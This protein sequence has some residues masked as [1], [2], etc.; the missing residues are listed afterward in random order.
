MRPGNSGVVMGI[1]ADV[2]GFC[3][4]ALRA[5]AATNALAHNADMKSC[6]CCVRIMRLDVSG[7]VRVTS[8]GWS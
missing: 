7:A 4:H 2:Y 3:V 1:H 8:T 6:T 5:T